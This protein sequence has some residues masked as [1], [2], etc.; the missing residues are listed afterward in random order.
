MLASATAGILSIR[1]R[2]GGGIKEGR[3]AL[4]SN[5]VASQPAVNDVPIHDN[6]LVIV[7]QWYTTP[8]SNPIQYM[9][10]RVR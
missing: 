10:V 2:G 4:P 1:K 5:H 6:T 7:I 3:A 9:M 8:A